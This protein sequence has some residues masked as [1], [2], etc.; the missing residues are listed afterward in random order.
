MM[1][2]LRR[3]CKLHSLPFKKIIWYGFL[4]NVA[5][6]FIQ[7]IFLYDM[8]HF[9]FWRATLYMWLAIIGDVMIVAGIALLARFLAGSENIHAMNAKGWG[10]LLITGFILSLL[11]EWIAIALGL[12]TYSRLMPTLVIFEEP[13][14][15]TPILQITFLPALSIWLA[16]RS[17]INKKQLI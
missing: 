13:V 1:R 15:L 3:D 10:A 6:E 8:W 9:S 12:W 2:I 17:K 16:V 14:G 5:W 11:L 7:C 4:L